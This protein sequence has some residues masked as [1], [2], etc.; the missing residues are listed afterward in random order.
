[1]TT[2]LT[3]A[4]SQF[5]GLAMADANTIFVTDYS[6]NKILSISY[7]GGSIVTLAGTGAAG[8]LDGLGTSATFNQPL[9]LAF[10]ASSKI[11]YITDSLN[12]R[13]RS[14]VP[15]LSNLT[16]SALQWGA[17]GDAGGC[18]S[19][20][21][22][23]L[24]VGSNMLISSSKGVV[25]TLAGSGN[26]GQ[27]NGAGSTASFNGLYGLVYVPST[28]FILAADTDN[29]CI[30][31]ISPAGVT[32][33]FSG[34]CGAAIAYAD[35]ASSVARF[36]KPRHIVFV[37][38][39]AVFVVADTNNH[40][41]RLVSPSGSVST[42]AGSCGAFGT[43]DGAS[44]VAR[45][46]EPYS[47][48]VL[49]SEVLAVADVGNHCLRL[50]TPSGSTSQLAGKNPGFAD[51]S[52]TSASFLD[53][54]GIAVLPGSTAASGIL[55][56]T[57]GYNNR[58]RLVTYPAGVVTTLAGTGNA[59]FSDGTGTSAS[60]Y[61]PFG[62]AL[63]P[64][65]INNTLVVSD[66]S[67]H[68]LRLVTYPGGIV[69]TL[70]GMSQGFSDGVGTSA[71]FNNPTCVAVDPASGSIFVADNHN[72]RIRRVLLP[73]V[74]PACDS[75]WHHTAL[76]YSPLASQYQLLAFLD[77]VLVFQQPATITIPLASASTL[78]IGW[79]GN[80]QEDGGSI[81]VGSLAEMR[82]YSRV[83]SLVEVRA[84]SPTAQLLPTV[85]L[86][87]QETIGSTASSSGLLWYG[88]HGTLYGDAVFVASS[89]TVANT[90]RA[91]QIGT[92][93]HMLFA[94]SSALLVPSFTLMHW[95]L[96]QYPQA[97]NYNQWLKS[98]FA[99]VN[100]PNT[101]D[102]N[103]CDRGNNGCTTG[104]EFKVYDS[105]GKK[106]IRPLLLTQGWQHVA[107]RVSGASVILFVN[108]NQSAS[109]PACDS[110]FFYTGQATSSTKSGQMAFGFPEAGVN[111][112]RGLVSDF[113]LYDVALT[114][115]QIALARTG[116]FLTTS[117]LRID[118][119]PSATAT[120]SASSTS[121]STASATP[122]ATSSATATASFS[123][124][125][126]ASGAVSPSA[127]PSATSTASAT[128]SATTTA[129]T[130]SS[131][132]AS[133]SSTATASLTPLA[134]TT[135]STSSSSS[136]TLSPSAY[137]TVSSIA[138]CP[139]GSW[140]PPG[141]PSDIKN[142]CVFCSPGTYAPLGVS[143]CL[144]CPS[145]TFGNRAGLTTAA[146]SGP[147]ASA[148]SCPAG[149]AFPPPAEIATSLTCSVPS[150]RALQ[151]SLGLQLWPAAGLGNPRAVGES[152]SAAKKSNG[153]EKK[154]SEVSQKP[155]MPLN[156]NA[157]ATPLYLHA[158]KQT[159]LLR[160]LRSANR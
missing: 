33:T 87:L 141:T 23:A 77:G 99:N 17:S 40:C 124:G 9:G 109:Q 152:P 112:A 18:S 98:N 76:V 57:D 56:V 15:P 133:S 6:T 79:S 36:A 108:G 135:P 78:R 22:L 115:E 14:L 49:P 1:M 92:T 106:C 24:N 86:K 149:T 140:R 69:S 2:F 5:S 63:L 30:R 90:A 44:A 128:A 129:T 55:A 117:P 132:T 8:S 54:Y 159:L 85:W 147:C 97:N 4:G 13:I 48:A 31:S 91:L 134:T 82:I 58:I 103:Q 148:A 52:G 126:S 150:S 113:R 131:A 144:L 123:P 80:V 84:L 7:P 107:V 158:P 110:G 16:Y 146:C 137:P 138:I 67:N 35:G 50:V 3:L 73:L 160:H 122:S 104:F 145:G 20:Q 65:P 102:A 143:P 142:F 66:Q 53:P 75:T 119:T 70:A 96:P 100:T 157:N 60:F 26:V 139:A 25:S 62:I 74:L 39:S 38:S 72:S 118:P 19:P 105:A 42:L 151:P 12:G 46:N 121:S 154:A 27:A 125:A 59:A 32:S 88:T 34:S 51:G 43:A 10:D 94:A 111:N 136:S 101:I 116:A 114:R 45:F 83:L 21:T 93:G 130:S 11:L 47:L 71:N 89:N 95:M 153:E 68:R 81:F 37:P 64:G 156:R 155:T 120:A 41:L 61:R 127:S 28:G 29:S